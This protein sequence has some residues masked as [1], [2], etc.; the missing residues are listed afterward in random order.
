MHRFNAAIRLIKTKRFARLIDVA[1]A[2]NFT[3]QSHLIRDIKAFSGM[4][5]TSL[6][7]KVDDFYHEQTGYYFV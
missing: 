7:Q 5:P 2:L 4:S 1:A 3:D 6:S